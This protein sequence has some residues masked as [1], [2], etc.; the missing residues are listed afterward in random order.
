MRRSLYAAEDEIERTPRPFE[1]QFLYGL[2]PLVRCKLFHKLLRQ[3]DGATA[4]SCFR[5]FKSHTLL[6]LKQLTDWMAHLS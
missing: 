1:F 4:T 2:L 3:V 5:L 6:V